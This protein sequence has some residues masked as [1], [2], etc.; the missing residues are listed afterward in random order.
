MKDFL[1]FLK[2][3][4]KAQ[5]AQEKAAAENEGS[6]G[7]VK[8][9]R[10]RLLKIMCIVSLVSIMIAVSFSWFT[11]SDTAIINGLTLNVVDPRNLVMGD[12]TLNGELRPISG[13]GVN[14]F[15]PELAETLVETTA[16]G[17]G[18]YVYDK[19]DGT[20]AKTADDISSSTATVKNVRVM[21]FSLSMTGGSEQLYLKSGTTITPSEGAPDYLVG[22]LRVSFLKKN[23][24]GTYEPILIWIPDVTSM[25]DSASTETE[26][27]ETETATE[28]ETTETETATETTSIESSYVFVTSVENVI[29]EKTVNI[30][31]ASG[32]LT[33]EGV[34]Y[35]WGPISEDVEFAEIDGTGYFRCVIW[36][37]GNDR[38]CNSELIDK[39]FKVSLNIAPKS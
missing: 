37:D 23:N 11:S 10:R 38:E 13:D 1:K 9:R 4:S 39:T 12:V 28:T 8:K 33:S 3:Y 30:S 36:L 34:R 32:D 24:A 22:A 25:R 20:Y 26:T 18:I 5:K 35:V 31:G 17:Y 2:E 19:V 21:D 29:T 16:D 7:K 6:Q 27:T 15:E 14:F